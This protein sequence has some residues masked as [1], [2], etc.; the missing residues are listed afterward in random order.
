MAAVRTEEITL[1]SPIRRALIAWNELEK[2]YLLC[3]IDVLG[4]EVDLKFY[5]VSIDTVSNLVFWSRFVNKLEP[6]HIV[7]QQ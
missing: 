6:W 2:R 7:M 1:P 4:C 3:L 5:I